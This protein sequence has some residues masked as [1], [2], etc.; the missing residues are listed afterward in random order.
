MLNYV[1]VIVSGLID[2]A[3]RFHLFTNLIIQKEKTQSNQLYSRGSYYQFTY[4]APSKWA[5]FVAKIKFFRIYPPTCNMK[6][7]SESKNVF[8]FFIEQRFGVMNVLSV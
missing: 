7:P 3:Y 1:I 5:K 6:V 4:I 2:W 8:K